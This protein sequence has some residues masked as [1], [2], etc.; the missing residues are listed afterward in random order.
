[1]HA[2]PAP[3][4]ARGSAA[5]AIGAV[6]RIITSPFRL[7]SLDKRRGST[8][9]PRAQQIARPEWRGADASVRHA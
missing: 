5:P 3:D 4:E 6:V 1:M 8:L 9:I 2:A 7:D